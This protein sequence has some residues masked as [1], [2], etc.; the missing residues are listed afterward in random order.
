MGTAS[1]GRRLAREVNPF[2]SDSVRSEAALRSLCATLG[3]RKSSGTSGAGW[4][5]KTEDV[6]VAVAEQDPWNPPARDLPARERDGHAA[7]RGG[8][9]CRL[10]LRSNDTAGVGQMTYSW[11]DWLWVVQLA[12]G[13]QRG[14][15][16]TVEGGM[17]ASMVV[18]QRPQDRDRNDPQGEEDGHYGAA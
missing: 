2:W 16:G 15:G 3:E 5:K 4:L 11:S 6:S 10:K 7:E 9:L 17:A 12:A 8:R 1:C 18:A 14:V 13:N